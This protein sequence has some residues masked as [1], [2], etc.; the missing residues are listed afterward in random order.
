[1]SEPVELRN[2]VCVCCVCEPLPEIQ[3]LESIVP[4]SSWAELEARR[5]SD[6]FFSSV[7]VGFLK[8][9]EKLKRNP[10]PSISNPHKL[11][12]HSLVLRVKLWPLHR[13]QSNLLPP[14][15]SKSTQCCQAHRAHKSQSWRA[16]ASAPHCL[17]R[18]CSFI[19]PIYITHMEVNRPQRRWKTTSPEPHVYLCA[20]HHPCAVC[21]LIPLENCTPGGRM[22]SRGRKVVER[23]G[24]GCIVLILMKGS[25]TL[26]LSQRPSQ[27]SCAPRMPAAHEDFYPFGI[28]ELSLALF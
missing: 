13:S 11:T 25:G 9:R 22:E 26:T 21:L 14:A 23:V 10:N 1:M 24:V 12:S 17:G 28:A 7:L 5:I 16:L 27:P 4:Q 2:C 15:L 8:C 20:R 3:H 18:M 19:S 6:C